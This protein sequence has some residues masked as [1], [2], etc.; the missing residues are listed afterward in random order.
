MNAPQDK[1]VFHSLAH[2]QVTLTNDV[3]DHLGGPKF[4]FCPTQYCTARAFPSIRN[5]EYLN[6]IGAK[7]A[8]QINVSTRGK[9][10]KMSPCH[11]IKKITNNYCCI[12]VHIKALTLLFKMRYSS[13]LCCK[14]WLCDNPKCCPYLL[15]PSSTQTYG[16]KILIC[17]TIVKNF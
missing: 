5:S 11:F 17:Y 6:T 1:E 12:W 4:V 13:P 9:S 7:L 2:A 10:V 15:D 14:K 3:H 8:P 16:C